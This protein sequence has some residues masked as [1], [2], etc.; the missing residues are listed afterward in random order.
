M[1]LIF[2]AWSSVNY[3]NVLDITLYL[4]NPNT[5]SWVSFAYQLGTSL[6]LWTV[7]LWFVTGL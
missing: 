3:W 7:A 6:H 2:F 1:F 5:Y 4:P